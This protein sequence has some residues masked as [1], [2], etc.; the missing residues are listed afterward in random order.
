[1]AITLRGLKVHRSVDFFLEVVGDRL[2]ELWG[3]TCQI[4]GKNIKV[5]GVELWG[6]RAGGDSTL[7]FEG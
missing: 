7:G 5:V 2:V 3:G 4:K 1:M 6:K